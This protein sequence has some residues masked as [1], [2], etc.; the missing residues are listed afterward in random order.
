MLMRTGELSKG[1]CSRRFKDAFEKF[2]GSLGIGVVIFCNGCGKRVF[3]F[4][5]III[6]DEVIVAFDG[7]IRISLEIMKNF[8]IIG[9]DAEL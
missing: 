6:E 1:D 5:E 9:N 2:K 7:S 3:Y 4:N 8:Q